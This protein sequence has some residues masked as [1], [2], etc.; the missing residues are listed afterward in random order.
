MSARVFPA[1]LTARSEGDLSEAEVSAAIAATA[2][3]YSFP[4]NLDTDPPVGGL[5]PRTQAEVLRDAVA[6]GWSARELL[7]ALAEQSARRRA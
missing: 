5:A 1:L 6:E 2:E 7:D 3:G 4:T